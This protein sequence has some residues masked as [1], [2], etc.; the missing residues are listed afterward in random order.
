MS[1]YGSEQMVMDDDILYPMWIES[2]N[3]VMDD[4][5]ALTL[6][7]NERIALTQTMR[8][9]LEVSNLRS[10]ASATVGWNPYVSGRMDTSDNVTE[11]AALLVLFDKYVPI[12]LETLKT[13][14]IIIKPVPEITHKQML[15]TLL[16]CLS[17]PIN[18][19]PE[20]ARDVYGTY[21]VYTCLW[22]FGSALF[23]D[24]A[25]TLAGANDDNRKSLSNDL[26][27]VANV[28]LNLYTISEMLQKI[29][30]KPLEKKSGRNF[31]LPDGK[32]LIYFIDDINMPEG[33]SPENEYLISPPAHSHFA[34]GIGDQKCMHVWSWSSILHTI[35]NDAMKS[36]SEFPRALN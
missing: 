23:K 18:C 36:Y 33:I 26:N 29:L 28:P 2:L 27:A 19:P 6:V 5:K 24:Q 21:F 22:A 25:I 11:E 14:F 34:D 32:T 4:N 3:T 35:L 10:T 9:P 13:K 30:E 16:D 15:C 12:C 17:T 31:D 20:N 7:N 1:V 8:L